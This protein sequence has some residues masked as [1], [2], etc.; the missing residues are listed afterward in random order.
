VGLD[1]ALAPMVGG[2]AVLA[3]LSDLPPLLCVLLTTTAVMGVLSAIREVHLLRRASRRA[4][5]DSTRSPG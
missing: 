1:V 3:W 4:F 5:I 2:L